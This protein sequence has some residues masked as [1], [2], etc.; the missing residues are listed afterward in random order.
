MSHESRERTAAEPDRRASRFSAWKRLVLYTREDVRDSVRERQAHVLTILFGLVGAGIAYRAGRTVARSPDATAEL[1]SQLLGP[2]TLLVPLV[3]L[4]FV[5]PG[6]VEKRTT[7][8]L[9]VLLGL[10][11]SRRAVVL[12]TWIGRSI[13]IVSTTLFAFVVAVPIALVM[14]VPADLALLALTGSA[15][16]LL[17]GTFVAIATA[18]S[19]IARTSTRATAGAFGVYVLFVLQI[20]Q[21]LPMLIL[22]VRHGF[23]YPETTPT[24]AE[25][26]GALNPITAFT[27]GIAAVSSTFASAPTDPAFY[28]R[29][30]FAAAIMVSWIVFA[31]GFGYR[32]FRGT[33][34]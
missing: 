18:I 26:V 14:D 20:W 34:L 27:N 2:L 29:P 30:A 8:A 19:A 7:G 23:T 31:V 32:R 11:F 21:Q 33:D 15:L 5:A 25:F 3:A 24:W 17:A 22:Y 4:G 12:G 28:E 9:T 1:S 6:L 13:V 16:A 10:P